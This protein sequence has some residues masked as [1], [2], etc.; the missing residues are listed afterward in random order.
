MINARR[1][2]PWLCL[3][4]AGT[5]AIATSAPALAQHPGGGGARGGSAPRGAPAGGGPHQHLDSRFSHNQYYYDRGYSVPRVS[6]GGREFRGPHGGRYWFNNGNW[7]NWHGGHWIVCPAPIG[8]F[9][10]FL[11]PF[12][13]TFWW[14]G[15]PYYYANDTYYWWDD[16]QQEYEVVTPPEGIQ[17]PAAT[18]APTID[19]LFIYPKNGQSSAQQA[20][21]QYECHQ[22]AV[23]QSGFDPSLPGASTSSGDPRKRDEYLRAQVSC[24]EG[25]GYSVK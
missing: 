3:L 17:A 14:Y 4:L 15:V 23:Q 12:Y 21:D 11:P 5:L 10:P 20:K 8:L 2:I 6:G 18:Q 16:T 9:V 24:L 1:S 19:R 25:R 7:Y 22:W 13:T